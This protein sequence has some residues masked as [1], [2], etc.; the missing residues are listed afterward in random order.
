MDSE[1][2][3]KTFVRS[4]H[5]LD[6]DLDGKRVLCSNITNAISIVDSDTK[7]LLNCFKE[8]K[9]IKEVCK[10]NFKC[11]EA[12]KELIKRGMIVEENADELK[13]LNALIES[14][15]KIGPYSFIFTVTLACNFRCT[16]CY[17]NK[18]PVEMTW[19]VADRCID[20]M[21]EKV[22]ESKQKDVR[23]IFY[24][25]EPLL[26]FD[27][28]KK[29]LIESRKRLPSDVKI[30]T[31]LITNGSLLTENVAKF[32]KK[33]DCKYSQISLDG[34][35]ELHD[36]RRPF[37]SGE[38]SFD[39]V[40]NGIKNA[41]ENF[42]QLIIRVNVD[43]TNEK[44]IPEFLD[45]LKHNNM[46]KTGVRVYFGP[47][48]STTKASEMHSRFCIPNYEYGESLVKLTKLAQNKG[49]VSYFDLPKLLYCRAYIKRDVAFSP[50][51]DI[52]PCLQRMEK[53]FVVG[54]VFSDPIY[55]EKA[56]KFYE[57]SPLDLEKCRECPIVGFC[58]GGCVSEAYH[59]YK[60]IN[61]VSCPVFKY[62]F[63]NLVKE[64]V[65]DRLSMK[66]EI[67]ERL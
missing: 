61:T 18:H 33:F 32:M 1:F 3:T 54:N 19:D 24:G 34:L 22:K 46:I 23:I 41:I 39:A 12:V 5:L 7:E 62:H 53:E 65:K 67:Y 11:K 38:G 49:I 50:I 31:G 36:K 8:P 60:D 29:I 20:F 15:K 25:G 52:L 57:R 4:K 63:E 44:Q 16:Y 43:K 2:L 35:R 30:S 55:N 64:Y 28:I 66:K 51:G 37:T 56:K 40:V 10:E 58:G 21:V 14:V 27:L 59:K 47:V 17:E 13:I 9:Y 42:D 6:F 26:K 45:W 48:T